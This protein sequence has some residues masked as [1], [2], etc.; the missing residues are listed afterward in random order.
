[1]CISRLG[2]GEGITEM[3]HG[4]RRVLT[5]QDIRSQYIR[6]AIV[7]AGWKSAESARNIISLPTV[8]ILPAKNQFTV[9]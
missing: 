6:P 3:C 7:A 8:C 5:E 9:D 1:M 4:I 2:T